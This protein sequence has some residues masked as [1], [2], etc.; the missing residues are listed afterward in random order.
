MKIL[1]FNGSPT[2][3]GNTAAM[4]DAFLD[5]VKDNG[6]DISVIRICQKK[7]AGCL[8]CEYCHTKGEGKCIQQD[9]TVGTSTLMPTAA[10]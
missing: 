3:N 10:R 5:G 6:H 9:D 2:Q 4:I 1:I 8:A 7:I